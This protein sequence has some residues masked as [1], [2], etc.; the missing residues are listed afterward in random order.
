MRSQDTDIGPRTSGVSGNGVTIALATPVQTNCSVDRGAEH[1]AGR[2]SDDE[3][4]KEV[5]PERRSDEVDHIGAEGVELAMGEIDDPHD[6]EDQG[7]PDAEERVSAAE[8]GRIGEMLEELVHRDGTSDISAFVFDRRLQRY[9]SR[10]SGYARRP[11]VGERQTLLGTTTLPF[12]I[13]I[14]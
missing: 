13:L 11:G 5:Q 12:S 10:A 7:E 6:P 9:E 3:G 14:R 1:A 8:R 2:D 4:E